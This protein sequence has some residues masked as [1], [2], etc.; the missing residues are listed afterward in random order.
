MK[1]VLVVLS[2]VVFLVIAIVLTTIWL[3]FD[4]D[5][6]ALDNIDISSSP[7][8][9][10]PL[11]ENVGETLTDRFTKYTKHVAPN[12]KP[13]HILGQ[14]GVRD[15]QMVRAREILEYHLTDVPG[16]KYGGSKTATANRMGDV[17]ATLIYTD[18]EENAF[19]MY[20]V[21]GPSKLAIQDLY[22]T[23]SPVEGDYEYVHN[24]GPAGE[25]FSR[26]AAY[27]EIMHLVHGKGLE[28]ELPDYHEAIVEAEQRAV[29]AGIYNY[30]P[31]APHEYIITGFDIY[32]GLWE[33]DPQGDGTSFG[34]EYPFH[35][36][37]EM[38][39]GDPDL[40]DL[41]EGFW[42]DTLTYTAYIAPEFE[43]IF[44]IAFDEATEYTLKSR[45]L[46]NVT[47]TGEGC[48]ES[49]TSRETWE[50]RWESSTGF[51]GSIG[52]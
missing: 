52:S 31:L 16:S 39:T 41:V 30:G 21:L 8:G 10:V 17:R 28:D 11:P 50:D 1:K 44:S 51:S 42:P 19:A 4:I 45:Y 3:R 25:H 48:S 18:T 47:L 20:P 33:H 37:D 46:V 6:E 23:E 38:K 13:I 15:L 35:T 34:D 14:S 26:D 9:V 5:Y 2:V 27:E 40:Y 49:C 7:L 36:K 29:D 32:F 43:G 22:A 24:A 12:G